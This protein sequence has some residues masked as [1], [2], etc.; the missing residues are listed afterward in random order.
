MKDDVEY[1]WIGMKRLKRS[2]RPIEKVI[3]WNTVRM[4]LNYKKIP[5]RTI[6]LDFHEIAPTL[7][8][9]LVHSGYSFR[10]PYASHFLELPRLTLYKRNKTS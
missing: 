4:M 7:K 10:S 3:D 1:G 9:L 6:F 8:N 2:R 5:Y